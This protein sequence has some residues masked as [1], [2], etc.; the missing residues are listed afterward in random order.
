MK[1]EN[2]KPGYE[3]VFTVMDY[4][5]GPRTGI[6]NYQGK[7]HLYECVFDEAKDDYSELFRLTPLDSE[8]FRLAMEDWEIWRRWLIAFYER[9]ADISTHPAL[10]HES[11]RHAE[12][13]GILDEVLVADP[14][15]AITRV[16]RF[17]V[18]QEPSLPINVIRRLQ[19]KW[20]QSAC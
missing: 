3:S 11:G 9:K 8:T 16:G 13:K 14:R 20:S 17:E 18:L 2:L 6:A 7:P 10:P 5:D 12:L 19:V 15:K 1:S 4:C